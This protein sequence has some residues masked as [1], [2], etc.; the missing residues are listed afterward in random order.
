ML[1]FTEKVAKFHAAAGMPA[2]YEDILDIKDRRKRLVCEEI[3]ELIDAI[4]EDDVPNTAKELA[5]A[6]YVLAGTLDE[7]ALQPDAGLEEAC[8]VILSETLQR[9]V[10]S[11]NEDLRAQNKAVAHM[12][13]VLLGVAAKLNI[14][15][16]EVFDAVHESN[17]TKVMPDGK[18]HRNEFGKIMKPDG[19]KAP[20]IVKVLASA[21]GFR[22]KD[23]G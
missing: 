15:I 8:H 23:A 11:L 13:I 6:L 17:M 3:Q 2:S 18:V 4:R 22:Q 9:F 14:P 1:E 10:I 20:D 21:Q 19:Y 7:M 12:E 16:D 5:D